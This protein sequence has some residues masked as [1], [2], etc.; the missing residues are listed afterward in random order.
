VLRVERGYVRPEDELVVPKSEPETDTE[1]GAVDAPAVE[2]VEPEVSSPADREEPE[3]DEGLKPISD[4]LLTELTAYRTLALRDALAQNPDVAWC[5]SR[6][7]AV[8]V[9][10]HMQTASR[11]PSAS[12]SLRPAG[13][14]RSTTISAM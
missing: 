5:M 13:R 1:A 6:G 14:H 8:R 2:G 4:R 7:M 9:L 10:S 12:M 11:R 3:E